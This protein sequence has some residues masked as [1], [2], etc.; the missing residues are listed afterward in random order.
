MLD[1]DDFVSVGLFVGLV[2]N[3]FH[4]CMQ[5]VG[6]VKPYCEAGSDG[7]FLSQSCTCTALNSAPEPRRCK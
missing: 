3:S 6:V 7:V 5:D 1:D 4:S 2:E